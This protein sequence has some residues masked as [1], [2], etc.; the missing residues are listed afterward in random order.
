MIKTMKNIYI[1]I[2]TSHTIYQLYKDIKNE[3]IWKWCWEHEVLEGQKQ[4]SIKSIPLVQAC[5]PSSAQ[6]WMCVF[7]PLAKKN[8]SIVCLSNPWMMLG[9]L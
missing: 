1:Y 6:K 3:K 4:R 7:I 2:H 9:K 8:N 5:G